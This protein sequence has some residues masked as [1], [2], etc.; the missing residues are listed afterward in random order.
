[1]ALLLC[2]WGNVEAINTKDIPALDFDR[3]IATHF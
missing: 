2:L 1:M 3:W